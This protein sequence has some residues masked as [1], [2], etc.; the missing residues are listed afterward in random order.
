MNPNAWNKRAGLLYLEAPAGVGYSESLSNDTITD[1]IVAQELINSLSIFLDRH[2]T[3]KKNELYITGSG[4]GAVFATYLARAIINRNKDPALIF[5]SKINL[6]G[7]LLGNPC[8]NPD[9]CFASGSERNS[10]YHY[11]FLH[12]RGFMTKPAYYDYLGK[13]AMVVDPFQ[14]YLARQKI[15]KEV[16]ATNTSA[17][18]I[19]AKCWNKDKAGNTINLGCEDESGAINYLNDPLFRTNWNIREGKTWAPCDI[20][21]WNQYHSGNGS[22][23]LINGLIKDGLRFVTI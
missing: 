8:V 9:E 21:I 4:Y 18:N 10:V 2:N 23:H 11:E 15:D 12:T 3:L 14:C 1:D 5:W 16:N 7:L 20:K 6:K 17:Y 13:C 22:L 19:Y